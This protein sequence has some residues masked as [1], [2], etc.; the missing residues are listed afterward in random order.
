MEAFP[1]II[2]FFLIFRSS[3]SEMFFRKF[4]GGYRYLPW[5]PITEVLQCRCC[6]HPLIEDLLRLILTSRLRMC[7]IMLEFPFLMYNL[8]ILKTSLTTL[9]R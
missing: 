4:S 3:F 5:P 7:V 1:A 9:L 6:V 8:Q 2:L